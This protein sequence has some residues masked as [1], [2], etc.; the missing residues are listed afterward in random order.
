MGLIGLGVVIASVPGGAGL[1]HSLTVV[2]VG[3]ATGGVGG[4]ALGAFLGWLAGPIFR[5]LVQ[6]LDERRA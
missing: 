1:D 6:E 3:V 4:A 2:L 5:E